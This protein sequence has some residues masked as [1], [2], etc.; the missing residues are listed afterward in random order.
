MGCWIIT[1]FSNTNSGNDQIFRFYCSFSLVL[2]AL[3]SYTLVSF[4]HC[5]AKVVLW[6]GKQLRTGRLNV[7]W[8]VLLLICRLW[9]RGSFTRYGVDFAIPFSDRLNRLTLGTGAGTSSGTG[10]GHGNKDWPGVKYP[11]WG[12]LPLRLVLGY[13]SYLLLIVLSSS[14]SLGMSGTATGR[15][16]LIDPGFVSS[17]ADGWETTFVNWVVGVEIAKIFR[18]TSE[19]GRWSMFSALLL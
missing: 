16:P 13:G 17:F 19:I 14:F 7:S 6:A 3:S 1:W 12:A 15:D 8:W 2:I 11:R 4:C 18:K 9:R 10:T 5:R